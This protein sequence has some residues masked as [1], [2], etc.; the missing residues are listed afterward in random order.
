[1]NPKMFKGLRVPVQ[2]I[3]I[4]HL[5][6]RHVIIIC[7]EGRTGGDLS[8]TAKMEESEEVPPWPLWLEVGHLENQTPDELWV[9]VPGQAERE[10]VHEVI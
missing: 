1:M 10:D 2:P 9:G 4:H 3:I 5:P 6:G 8:V 7:Y